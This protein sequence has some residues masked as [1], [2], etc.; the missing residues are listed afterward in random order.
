M[1]AGTQTA[2]AV[3][4]PISRLGGGFM[5]SR[6]VK[7]ASQEVGLPGW[8]TYFR[9]RCGVLGEAETDVVT[10][11]AVFFPDAAVRE[12]WE[13]GQTVPAA[14]AAYRYAKACQQWGRRK[15]AGFDS[16]ARLAELLGRVAEQA[17]VAGAPLFAG[18]REM[19]LPDDPPG[20]LAQLAH[21]LRE[22]RG[23]L[24]AVAVLASGLAPLEAVLTSQYGADNARFFGW[25]EPYPELGEDVRRRRARAEELTGELI[26]PAFAALSE[27]E[28]AELVKLLDG[29]MGT[30][31]P[32]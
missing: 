27:S 14:D 29:A 22:H 5:M 17:D 24:H 31:F 1:T 3:K 4:D 20:R 2:E 25:P 9:G 15:L 18:W 21:V 23:G 12:G 6:E 13:D 11:V 26:A 19:P 32:D 30:A 10:S 8:Q 28:T 16:C 7:Q